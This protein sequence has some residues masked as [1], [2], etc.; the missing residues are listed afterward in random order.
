MLIDVV[1]R[2]VRAHFGGDMY[3]VSVKV[4]TPNDMYIAVA[5]EH[6]LGKALRRARE[7]LRKSISKGASVFDY[8]LRKSRQM[9]ESF[10][11]AL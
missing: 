5:T 6:N 7:T 2:Q 10:T 3:Y 1:L 4:T 9:K 11:L 8:E